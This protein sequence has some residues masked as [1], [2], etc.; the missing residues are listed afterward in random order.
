MWGSGGTAQPFSTSALD[1]SGWSASRPSRFNP[2]DRTAQYP[3]VAVMSRNLAGRTEDIPEK[4]QD[5]GVQSECVPT[6]QKP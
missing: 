1:A 4:R 6:E 2:G 3:L 5:S